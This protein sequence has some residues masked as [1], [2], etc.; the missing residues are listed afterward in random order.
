MGGHGVEFPPIIT[1]N[2]VD[3]NI[4]LDRYTIGR[5]DL[6]MIIS[7]LFLFQ[8]LLAYKELGKSDF[9]N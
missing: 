9:L 4:P 8:K 1:S 6:V 2:C 7:I 3:V 5:S